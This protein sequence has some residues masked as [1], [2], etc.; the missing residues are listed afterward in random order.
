MLLL[1]HSLVVGLCL[2]TA[3]V[4]ESVQVVCF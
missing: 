4:F 1:I 2:A 3:M